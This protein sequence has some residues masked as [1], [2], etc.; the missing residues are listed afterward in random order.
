MKALKNY[1]YAS[2]ANI[3]SLKYQNLKNKYF[4]LMP[5]YR[6]IQVNKFIKEEDK[7]RNIAVFALLLHLAEL[8]GY[9]NKLDIKKDENQKPY[10]LN[11]P[12]YFSLSHSGDY[13][14]AAISD[15][16]IG[17]DVQKRIKTKE[18]L[19]KYVRFPNEK[20]DFYTLWCVKE[21]Y[22]KLL[23]KGLEIP[24]QTIKFKDIKKEYLIKLFK[25]K[26]HQFAIACDKK[27]SSIKI[28]S[29]KLSY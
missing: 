5:K 19:D 13:V 11:N 21:A 6:Q 24:F 12:F 27:T 4:N 22:T 1:V 15:K 18:N 10:I 7:I 28:Q 3:S 9:K 25:I 17:I 20:D 14:F 2:Y 26:N 29:R 16:P 23:G 8:I